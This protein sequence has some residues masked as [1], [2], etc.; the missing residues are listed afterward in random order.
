MKVPA[1]HRCDFKTAVELFL[2]DRF[3]IAAIVRPVEN[4]DVAVPVSVGNSGFPGCRFHDFN[5]VAGFFCFNQLL[6]CAY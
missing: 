1:Y 2:R 6:V 3:I 5:G 4:L